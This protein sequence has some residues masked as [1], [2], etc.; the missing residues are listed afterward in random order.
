MRQRIHRR[1]IGGRYIAREQ[2]PQ[3]DEHQRGECGN[4]EHHLHPCSLQDAPVLDRKR[5]EHHRCAQHK[6][7]VDAQRQVG[8]DPAQIQQRELP[9]VDRRVGRK[10]DA[11]DVARSQTGAD[12]QHG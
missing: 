3:A 9:G 7:G 6:G 10:Q 11:Q 8:T 12:G 4:A 2:W 1:Q 5:G